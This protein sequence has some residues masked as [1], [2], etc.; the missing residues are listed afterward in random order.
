MTGGITGLVPATVAAVGFVGSNF[1]ENAVT[2]WG[3]GVADRD[4]SVKKAVDV[5]D[6]SFNDDDDPI[7]EFVVLVGGFDTEL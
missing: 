4:T 7:V 5:L 6:E 2:V 3:R 1:D